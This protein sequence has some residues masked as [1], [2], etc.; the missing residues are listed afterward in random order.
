[1]EGDADKAPSPRE[2]LLYGGNRSEAPGGQDTCGLSVAGS[3]L[4][5]GCSSLCFSR[6]QEVTSGDP[7][8]GWGGASPSCSFP[9]PLDEL[10]E[11]QGKPLGAGSQTRQSVG[12]SSL[13]SCGRSEV[14]G[15]PR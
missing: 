1:M 7:P 11:R 9:A 2:S 13:H 12:V 8:E 4:L 14:T 3:G 10:G 5:G 15:S 6:P